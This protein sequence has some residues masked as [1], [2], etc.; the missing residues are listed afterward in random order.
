MLF[1][2]FLNFCYCHVRE[3][4][5]ETKKTL[6]SL[7]DSKLE[8]IMQKLYEINRKVDNTLSSLSFI[9]NKVDK[10]LS[11][12][13][14]LEEAK[15]VSDKKIAKLKLDLKIANDNLLAYQEALN[16]LEQYSHRECLEIQQI[17]LISQDTSREYRRYRKTSS[18][19]YGG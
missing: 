6:E 15:K 4:N 12:L 1:V 18:K 3:A 16:D 19:L 7:L 13:K 2:L 17:P 11:K 14:K 9:S 5:R 10:A 8:I